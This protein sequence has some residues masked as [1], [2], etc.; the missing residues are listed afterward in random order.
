MSLPVNYF[1]CYSRGKDSAESIARHI[2]KISGLRKLSWF[3]P[4][5]QRNWETGWNLFWLRLY[6][7]WASFVERKATAGFWQAG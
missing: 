7:A 2:F 6:Q 1:R 5:C 3:K 4:S